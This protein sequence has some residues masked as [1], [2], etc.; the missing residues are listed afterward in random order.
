[1]LRKQILP[2]LLFLAFL[3]TGCGR[4]PTAAR[5]KLT[6]MDVPLTEREFIETA[7]QDDP[8]GTGL[9]PDVGMTQEERDRILRTPPMIAALANQLE[10]MRFLVARRAEANPQDEK[11]GTAQMAAAWN[12]NEFLSLVAEGVDPNKIAYAGMRSVM[13]ALWEDHIDKSDPG[14]RDRDGRTAFMR[15][16]VEGAPRQ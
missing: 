4:G 14:L 2:L 13:F 15:A 1:M 7:R 6:P 11:S 3:F 12:G 10:I 16:G 9:F 5:M 8:T